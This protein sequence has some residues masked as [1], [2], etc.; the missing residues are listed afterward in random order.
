MQ[1]AVDELKLFR[2]SALGIDYV[3]NERIKIHHPT[4]N[5]ICD[6]G[7]QQY[8]GMATGLTCNPSAYKVALHDMGIDYETLNDFDFFVMM[9]QSMPQ[10]STKL[11]LGDLDLS[12]LKPG[13]NSQTD[14][15]VLC[16]EEDGEPKAVIDRAI[17]TQMAN[18]IRKIHGF[19]KKVE[20]P[21]DN[22]TK[23][24][25]IERERKRIARG[26][27]TKYKSLLKPLISSMVN[28]PGFKYDYTTVWDLPITVFNDSV[29]RIQK[30]L[31]YVQTMQ[32]AYA[33]TV[34]LKKINTEELNWLN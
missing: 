4:L 31:H 20:K 28:Q 3:I 14:E 34:D 12:K 15:M 33:G 5:E 18:Y 32:G 19:E 17:Y 2:Q 9:C 8:Y 11:L 10:E 27:K 1:M 6:F 24:Y 26:K 29:S 21:A 22:H 23:M 16:E 25:L 7:E 30:Y 13:H